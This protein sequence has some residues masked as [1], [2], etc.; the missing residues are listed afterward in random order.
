MTILLL[1]LHVH[2]IVLFFD[3]I[4]HLL[5]T[6]MTIR[7]ERYS[8]GIARLRFLDQGNSLHDSRMMMMLLLLFRDEMMVI[9]TRRAN[10]RL[11]RWTPSTDWR[12]VVP[13]Q[14]GRTVW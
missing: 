7:V 6:R 3:Y 8:F 13:L 4:V 1:L 12:A 5:L 14:S 10:E 11:V 2:R 9:S